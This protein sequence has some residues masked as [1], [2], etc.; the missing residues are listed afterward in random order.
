[1]SEQIENNVPSAGPLKRAW[2]YLGVTAIA[3]SAFAAAIVLGNVAAGAPPQADENAWAHLFQLAMAAQIPL[4]LLVLGLADWRQKPRVLILL[5]L[6]IAAA[7][8]A[9]GLLAWSGY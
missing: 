5:G 8:T 9:F 7:A 1:M 6:Q 3:L 4:M 2:V